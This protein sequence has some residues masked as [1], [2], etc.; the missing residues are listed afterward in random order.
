LRDSPKFKKYMGTAASSKDRVIGR[1][2][3]A[4]EIFTPEQNK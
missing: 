3:I 1:V 2:R 4:V